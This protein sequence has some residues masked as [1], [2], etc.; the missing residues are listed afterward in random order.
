MDTSSVDIGVEDTD[1]VDIGMVYIKKVVIEIS[2]TR[3]VSTLHSSSNRYPL[4]SPTT[5][6][7]LC[8]PSHH[9]LHVYKI[10]NTY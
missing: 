7:M 8:N 3:L 5:A 6:G 4:F 2:L 10:Y 9:V 1:F